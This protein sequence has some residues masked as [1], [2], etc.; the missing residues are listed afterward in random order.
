M[1]AGM[2]GW[3]GT[4]GAYSA[5]RVYIVHG[6]TGKRRL[7]GLFGS[8]SLPGFGRME[9]KT[10]VSGAAGLGDGRWIGQGGCGKSIKIGFCL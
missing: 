4:V 5:R 8:S 3:M 2:D 10:A 6:L 9:Q 7:V 1:Y